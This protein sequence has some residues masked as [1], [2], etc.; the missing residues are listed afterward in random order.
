MRSHYVEP[1]YA[2]DVV[3]LGGKSVGY[4]VKEWVSDLA[5]LVDAVRRVGSGRGGHRPRDRGLASL[6]ILCLILISYSAPTCW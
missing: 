3:A 2:A 1:A 5:E 4:L 6:V